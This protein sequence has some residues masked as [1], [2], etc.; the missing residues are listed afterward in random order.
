MKQTER[1]K[2][3]FPVIYKITKWISLLFL[4]LAFLFGF[5]VQEFFV[6]FLICLGIG[7]IGMFVM[8]FIEKNYDRTKFRRSV[9]ILFFYL[10]ALLLFLMMIYNYG[11]F[12]SI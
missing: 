5:D 2:S 3:E 6:L 10:I 12:K 7:S 1:N 9:F 4:M 11:P 8:L